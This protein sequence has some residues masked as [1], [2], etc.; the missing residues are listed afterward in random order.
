MS[1]ADICMVISAVGFVYLLLIAIMISS[2]SVS[3]ERMEPGEGSS[4]AFYLA[5]FVYLIIFGV[6]AYSKYGTQANKESIEKFLTR[7]QRKNQGY[8]PLNEMGSATARKPQEVL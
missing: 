8:V 7:A 1:K 4:A 2:D 5:A 3:V 6:L